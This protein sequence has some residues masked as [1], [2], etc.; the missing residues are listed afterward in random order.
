MTITKAYHNVHIT[1][2]AKPSLIYVQ[3]LKLLLLSNDKTNGGTTLD[4]E[5]DLIEFV[6]KQDQLLEIAYQVTWKT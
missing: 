4:K 6:S 5:K 3:R 2:I 1:D